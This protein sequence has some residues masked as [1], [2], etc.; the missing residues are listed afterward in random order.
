MNERQRESGGDHGNQY[1]GGKLAVTAD[2][3]YPPKAP[4]E[5]RKSTAQAAKEVTA[6][7]RYPLAEAVANQAAASVKG[8]RKKSTDAFRST[9][10][11]VGAYIAQPRGCRL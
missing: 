2:L 9:A 7:L 6:D 3:R 5:Q 8:E 10:K 11:A 4:A 1:T